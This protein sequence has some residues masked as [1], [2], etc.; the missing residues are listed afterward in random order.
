MS[1]EDRQRWSHYYIMISEISEAAFELYS[2][3]WPLRP[4]KVKWLWSSSIALLWTN[5][6]ALSCGLKTNILSNEHADLEQ[7]TDRGYFQTPSVVQA[8]VSDFHALYEWSCLVIL[9]ARGHRLGTKWALLLNFRIA[10]TA[11]LATK[12]LGEHLRRDAQHMRVT[13]ARLLGSGPAS[14]PAKGQMAPAAPQQ[15]HSGS[16]AQWDAVGA[17]APR[18]P[19]CATTK[20]RQPSP[21]K[22]LYSTS[23]ARAFTGEKRQKLGDGGVAALVEKSWRGERLM[24]RGFVVLFILLWSSILSCS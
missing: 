16:R 10:I 19:L 7:T 22:A 14:Q 11:V 9:L 24:L 13:G 5:I 12:K 8:L 21:T 6:R 1:L 3:L 20:T 4:G 2:K 18:G 17:A 23:T 15:L